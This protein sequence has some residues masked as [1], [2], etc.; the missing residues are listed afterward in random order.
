MYDINMAL[1]HFRKILEGQME[2]KDDEGNVTLDLGGST[3]VFEAKEIAAVR[4]RVEF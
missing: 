3:R 2:F 4:L 1:E